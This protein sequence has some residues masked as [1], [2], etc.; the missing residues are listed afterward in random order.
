MTNKLAH[1]PSTYPE[2]VAAW[3]SAIEPLADL[4]EQL[5][6]EQWDEPSILPGWT[7]ADIVAHVVGIE[8]DLLGEPTPQVDVDWDLLPHA[9]DLFSRY[10][11]LAVAARRG[12]PQVEVCSE[13]RAA[14]AARRQLL[15]RQPQDL[16]EIISGPGGWELPRGVVLRMRCFDI[17]VHDQDIR[18]SIGEPGDLDTVAAVVAARQML[19]GLGRIW[20]RSVRPDPTDTALLRITEPGVSFDVLLSLDEQG[21]GRA[22]LVAPDT[23]TSATTTLTT[24]WPNFAAGCA[25]RSTFDPQGVHIDGDRTIGSRL[26]DNLNIAP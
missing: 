18:A 9:N 12:V 7:N 11:E 19:N 15:D 2:L 25:G 13:L 3:S 8:R 23:A 21:R 26:T 1:E 24:S 4:A 5:T 6:P 20:A 17:W 14:I 10:T 22:G 16:G